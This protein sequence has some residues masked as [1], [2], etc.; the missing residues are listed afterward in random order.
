MVFNL[1]DLVGPSNWSKKGALHS[2]TFWGMGTKLQALIMTDLAANSTNNPEDW[3]K[4]MAANKSSIQRM[5]HSA[6]NQETFRVAI[7]SNERV[8]VTRWGLE[9]NDV[10]EDTEYPGIDQL[11]DWI[12]SAVATLALFEPEGDKPEL[13]G[14]GRRIS[15]R[16]FWVYQP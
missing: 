11:P 2:K 7:V 14:V 9:Q 16:V 10:V 12:Q 13:P 1:D 5:V 4:A 3:V 15:E 6:L 8:V